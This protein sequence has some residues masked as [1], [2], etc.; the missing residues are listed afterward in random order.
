MILEEFKRVLFI[1]KGI[2][3]ILIL[4]IVSVLIYV[5]YNKNYIEKEQYQVLSESYI[6]YEGPLTEEKL[7]ELKTEYEKQEDGEGWLQYAYKS[8]YEHADNAFKEMDEPFL[9]YANGWNSLIA[10]LAD[11]NGLL[12]ALLIFAVMI[13]AFDAGNN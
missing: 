7:M 12:I 4:L 2:C 9:V 1:Q 8:I 10:N 13:F 11:N 6:P 3:L 5:N